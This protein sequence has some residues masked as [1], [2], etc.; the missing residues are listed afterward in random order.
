MAITTHLLNLAS[1]QYNKSNE[2]CVNSEAE[3]MHI[4]LPVCFIAYSLRVPISAGVL[5]TSG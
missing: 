1:R 5:S 3:T 4:F 2:V